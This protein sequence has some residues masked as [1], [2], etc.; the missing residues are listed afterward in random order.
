MISFPYI[1]ELLSPKRDA[2]EKLEGLL[3]RFAD[4]Y[5]QSLGSG[6][7][8]S[9]PDNPMGQLRYGLI[10]CI[11]KRGLIVDSNK[12][13]MN[14]NTFHS[15]N[16]LDDILTKALNIGI[17]KLLVIRGDGGPDV[18]KLDPGSI[19]GKQSIAT[20]ADLLRYINTRYPLNFITGVGFNPYKIISFELKHMQGKVEAGA[21][22][23][24]TQPI[25]GN[26]ANV[27]RV[28]E[29]ELPL[30]VEA[31]M[32]KNIDL[33]YKSVGGELDDTLQDYDPLTNVKSLHAAYPDS[34]IYLA[35][36]SFKD[37][38]QKMLPKLS[39]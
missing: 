23:V 9:V 7:G 20:T 22:F 27:D 15:K 36:L 28:K 3:D 4:R 1:I 24:V 34:C 35:L 19:G 11:E 13:I 8:I 29:Y 18:P 25:I 5:E 12:V 2:G 33:F 31:W 17:K 21:K 37:N 10:E 30:V 39:V 6:C 16:E 38:W 32:S 26:N 14:L